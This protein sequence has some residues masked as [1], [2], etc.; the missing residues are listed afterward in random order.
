MIP[1]T[2]D[3]Y[4]LTTDDYMSGSENVSIGK[5]LPTDTYEY[6][7]TSGKPLYSADCSVKLDD[8]VYLWHVARGS[9]FGTNAAWCV[10]KS[11]T[12]NLQIAKNVT[13]DNPAFGLQLCNID[14]ESFKRYPKGRMCYDY[15]SY[16]WFNYVNSRLFLDINRTK[17]CMRPRPY[18]YDKNLNTIV[19]QSVQ[20]VANYINSDPENRFIAYI[21]MELYHG[22]SF[23]RTMDKTY[24][25]NT[26]LR[27]V[28]CADILTDRP[29]PNNA[30]G[31][32]TDMLYDFNDTYNATWR[33]DK[34]YSPFV[35]CYSGLWYSGD[36]QTDNNI[37][38]GFMQN[39]SVSNIRNGSYSPNHGD[40]V[41]GGFIKYN[42]AIQDF[43]DVSYKWTVKVWYVEGGVFLDN[44]YPLDSLPNN[45]NIRFFT[46]LEIVDKKGLSAGAA[47]QAAVKHECAFVG[48]Y[49]ADTLDDAQNTQ[50][51]IAS[52]RIF[53]PEFVGGTT[54]GRYFTGDDIPNVPYANSTSVSDSAFKYDPGIIP[55]D[56]GDL[57]TN[58]Y[59]AT[60]GGSTNLYCFTDNEF[61]D[62][63]EWLNTDYVPTDETE[64]IQDFKGENPGDYVVS[65]KYFPFDLPYSGDAPVSVYVGRLDTGLL[66][67]PLKKQI[68][69][70]SLY[71]LGSF[72]IQPPYVYDDF[73]IQYCK[74]LLYIPWCGY[75]E[76]DPVVFAKSPDNSYHYL[77]VSL[78]VDYTTGS[79]MG[80]I[81]RDKQ[82][83]QTINGTCGIDIPLSAMNQGSYQ[84]AIKQAE[85]A[86]SNAETSRVMSFLG[87]AGS[88]ITT[89]GSGITGNL[90]GLALGVMGMVGSV[91]TIE[92]AYNK[93]ESAQYALEHTS[94]SVGQVSGASP[95]NNAYMDQTPILF[96]YR[97]A[98]LNG[99][100]PSVYGHTVGY[101]CSINGKLSN[102]SG[103]TVCNSWDLSGI[104]CTAEE[105][106]MI[107]QYLSGGVIV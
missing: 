79:C 46:S 60:I 45:H 29:I 41:T 106:A 42:D 1:W 71:N 63:M 66:R 3:I 30:T 61:K 74:M 51:G 37:N 17:F 5:L 50:L 104:S 2:Y 62:L 70:N 14:S 102:F 28:I 95:L 13:E 9:S 33:T 20:S 82:L 24:I 98:M 87:L 59:T 38:I 67:V 4:G 22:D 84:N 103:L 90:P 93:V 55:E 35:Q 92:N 107:S 77:N 99:F 94:V 49:F 69:G 85:I 6:F 97:P 101:A 100:D 47:L 16:L 53:L 96:I 19:P 25:I 72:L 64:F 57:E 32:K 40:K 68:G 86:L 15:W 75:T 81:Y 91:G 12:L 34:Q 11:D 58:H 10:E 23:P 44:G 88:A 8:S 73:R 78:H 76:L 48:F 105:K 54:T 18:V 39:R 31:A 56:G 65:V 36:L 7:N 26:A 83:I 52:N 27:G 21:N 80:L 89:V 43:D